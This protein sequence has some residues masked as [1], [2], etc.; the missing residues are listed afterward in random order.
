MAE[1]RND[2]LVPQAELE[3]LLRQLGRSL[4]V[5][6][7]PDYATRVRERLTAASPTIQPVVP[8]RRTSSLGWLRPVAMAAVILVLA[9]AVVLSVPATREA[10]A[11]MF[12]FS[13]VRVRTLPTAAPSPRTTL[14]AD[15]DLGEPVTLDQA[16][17]QVSFPVSVPSVPELGAPDAVYVRDE[18]GLESVSLVYGR[19]AGFPATVDSQVGVLVSESSGTAMPYFEKLIE[20]GAPM[21]QVT[22]AGR[23][24]GLYFP[25]PHEVLV[26]SP[27]GVVHEDRPRLSAPTLVW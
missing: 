20:A 15:L 23:W 19:S 3:A 11:E 18:R 9:V 22:V 25:T 10:V 6:A 27:D 7:A 4:D 24:P 13:G 2:R 1:D 17:R 8:D 16:R 21:T 5:P 26:R 12:G 14:D